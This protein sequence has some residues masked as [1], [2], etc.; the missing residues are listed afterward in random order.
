METVSALYLVEEVR[1][2]HLAEEDNAL[3]MV[4]QGSAPK[5]VKVSAP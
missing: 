3:Y 4:E 1:N 5:L 2:P